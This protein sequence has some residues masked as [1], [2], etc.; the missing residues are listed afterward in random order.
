MRSYALIQTAIA[1]RI[2]RENRHAQNIISIFLATI[3][4]NKSL[5]FSEFSFPYNV[6]H[7]FFLSV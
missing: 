7:N 4:K 1:I 3:K 5:I 6:K 2:K